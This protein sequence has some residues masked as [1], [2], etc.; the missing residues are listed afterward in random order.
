MC[1]YTLYGRTKEDLSRPWEETRAGKLTELLSPPFMEQT[2]SIRDFRPPP[3][4][5]LAREMKF[6]PS[7]LFFFASHPP[8]R[9]TAVVCS[10]TAEE[11]VF[12]Y[13]LLL[14]SAFNPFSTREVRE[15]EVLILRN[16]IFSRVYKHEIEVQYRTYYKQSCSQRI[17]T[18]FLCRYPANCFLCVLSQTQK[19]YLVP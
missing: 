4:S 13:L 1:S 19:P 10:N 14:R 11:K 7:R 2:F 15:K 5:L 12:A 6:R 18:V 16:F 17:A 8:S 3:L 9:Y